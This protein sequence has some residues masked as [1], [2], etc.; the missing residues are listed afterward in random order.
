M[1][2]YYSRHE[3]SNSDLSSLK[4]YLTGYD[5]T[6]PTD[7]YR[8][9][10]L[11]DFMITEPHKVDAYKLTAGDFSYSKAEFEKAEKMRAA[12]YRDPFC[13]EITKGAD[14]QKI[15]V[16]KDFMIEYDNIRFSLDVR[17][18]WDIWR[19]QLGWGGDIKSTTATTHQQFEAA[20]YHFG[21]PRQRAWYMDIA[22]QQ[23]YNADR[24]SLIGIS[25]VNEKVFVLPIRRGD[26]FYNTGKEDYQQWSFRWW[27]LFEDLKK[28][29]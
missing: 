1:D 11:I 17:C 22:Q 2:P 29:A 9:G 16:Q 24:D 21:Y 14:T 19:E 26:D 13:R 23:G 25:K 3:V 6:E 28:T 18:K 8:F 15:M 27:M 12:F 7:A 10:N 4:K 20:C 5:D